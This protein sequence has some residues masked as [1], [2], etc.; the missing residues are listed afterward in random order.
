MR[1][2]ETS[3]EAVVKDVNGQMLLES[4]N[5]QKRWTEYFE[6]LLNVEDAREADIV[7]VEGGAQM[8]VLGEI[9]VADITKKNVREAVEVM[10]GRGG[11]SIWMSC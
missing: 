4:G 8:P 11:P 7:A 10:D 5:V 9:L 3:K 1:K 2:G 6:D